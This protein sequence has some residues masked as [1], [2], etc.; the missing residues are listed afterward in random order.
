MCLSYHTQLKTLFFHSK[1]KSRLH[2][3]NE[4]PQV[5][6]LEVSAAFLRDVADMCVVFS[7]LQ[8]RIPFCCQTEI[9]KRWRI[10][11]TQTGTSQPLPSLP[12]MRPPYS[13]DQFWL[14]PFRQGLP[15]PPSPPSFFTI[16]PRE[17]SRNLRIQCNSSNLMNDPLL[18]HT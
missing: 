10:T 1:S 13:V 7:M 8:D 12:I 14:W 2:A 11:P 9:S 3:L 15:L 6:L 5:S 4:T 16:Q 18:I 17:T